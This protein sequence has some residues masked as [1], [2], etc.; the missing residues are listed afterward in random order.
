MEAAAAAAP[1]VPASNLELE[2]LFAEMDE[3]ERRDSRR[4]KKSRA[5]KKLEK[6]T[7]VALSKLK[8][9]QVAR[10]EKERE[11]LRAEERRRALAEKKAEQ[12]VLKF[13]RL[14]QKNY[15]SILGDVRDAL[16]EAEMAAFNLESENAELH[17]FLDEVEREHSKSHHDYIAKLQDHLALVEAQIGAPLQD[18]SAS[19][20]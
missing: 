17:L 20:E 2:A 9:Q 8:K 12:S 16:V 4:Q 3:Q 10:R 19:G 18:H 6:E 15:E 11:E 7:T 5:V 14:R 1:V 13:A